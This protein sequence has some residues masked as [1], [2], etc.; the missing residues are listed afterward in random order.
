MKAWPEVGDRLVGTGYR[1]GYEGVVL[2]VEDD[3]LGKRV[4]LALEGH[5]FSEDCD[6]WTFF[7]NWQREFDVAPEI[8]EWEG[9]LELT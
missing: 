8:N 9:N 4:F 3:I 1:E 6:G 5:I 7:E 2:K